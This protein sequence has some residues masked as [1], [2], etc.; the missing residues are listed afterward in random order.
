MTSILDAKSLAGFAQKKFDCDVS[1]LEEFCRQCT[2]D[3]TGYGVCSKG[4]HDIS[5]ENTI[6]CFEGGRHNLET[7]TCV[8]LDCFLSELGRDTISQIDGTTK[9]PK[10]KKSKGDNEI[11]D[12]TEFAQMLMSQVHFLSLRDTREILYYENGIYRFGGEV[13]IEEMAESLVS[14]YTTCTT[15]IRVEITNSIRSRTYVDREAF[16]ADVNILNVKNGLYNI[17]DGT[18]TPHNPSYASR[19][20]LNVEYHPG[21][22]PKRFVSFMEEILPDIEDRTMVYEMFGAI[23][24]SRILDLQKICVFVGDGA[25][26]KSTLLKTMTDIIGVKNCSFRSMHSLIYNRFAASDLDGK[27]A[28]IYADIS[29]DEMKNIGLIKNLVSGDETSV[30]KK[31][32][33]SFTM[34]NIAKMFFSCNRLPDIEDETGGVF[35]RF[36]IIEFLTEFHGGDAKARLIDELI[37]DSEKSGILNLLVQHANTILK[38]GEFTYAREVNSI[39]KEWKERVDMVIS[40]VNKSVEP[41]PESNIAKDIL[42]TEYV[43][44]C[45]TNNERPKGQKIFS[46][47]MSTFGY[48]WDKRRWEGKAQNVWVGIRFKDSATPNGTD[49]TPDDTDAPKPDTR[50]DVSK[51][52]ISDGT[53]LGIVDILKPESPKQSIVGD[54]FTA[55]AD[56]NGLLQYTS[57]VT[58]MVKCQKWTKEEATVYIEE[59]VSGKKLVTS[60]PTKKRW[61]CK[62]GAGPY[63]SGE[64]AFAGKPIEEYHKGD[65]HE[66][67]F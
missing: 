47:K 29:A 20:Q 26:G 36:H 7:S 67:I 17:H 37:Q 43:K 23:L 31:N 22:A 52:E 65:G 2:G 5:L 21:I 34:K 1:R 38:N 25:N 9:T 39:R 48:K 12:T 3:N 4:E 57:L 8:H 27:L 35:R 10:P 49:I 41:H 61:R 28:N 24:V 45:E 54:I 62:C 15:S 19:I 14:Q 11:P 55:L 46:Q 50:H 44:Y 6:F 40:F 30:E 59:L 58:E 32:K 53:M 16:D 33:S 13:L 51:P 64:V 42:Y 56:E 18:F 66:I 63:V 60:Q